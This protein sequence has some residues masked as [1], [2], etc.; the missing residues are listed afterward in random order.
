MSTPGARWMMAGIVMGRVVFAVP[1]AISASEVVISAISG[2]MRALVTCVPRR[3]RPSTS[4]GRGCTSVPVVPAGVEVTEVWAHTGHEH[5]RI[6]SRVRRIR[7]PIDVIVLPP[8]E[9]PGVSFGS[10]RMQRA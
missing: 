9:P 8:S 3:G 10:G 5:A 2:V 7:G 6:A 1:R 4:H